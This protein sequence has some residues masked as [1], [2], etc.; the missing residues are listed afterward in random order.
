MP[1]RQ[2]FDLS[3]IDDFV[4]RCW[5]VYHIMGSEDTAAYATLG[6]GSILLRRWGGIISGTGCRDMERG[7]WRMQER[8]RSSHDTQ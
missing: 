3:I 8:R 1:C 7:P 6:I 2:R 5:Y 4:V